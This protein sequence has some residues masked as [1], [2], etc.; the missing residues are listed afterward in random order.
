MRRGEFLLIMAFLTITSSFAK[1]NP[2]LTKGDTPRAPE[3]NARVETQDSGAPSAPE[4]SLPKLIAG[5][6]TLRSAYFNTL[7]IL[8]SSNECSNFFRGSSASVEVFKQ[9]FDKVKKDHVSAPIG[10]QMT[11]MTTNVINTQT[12]NRYRLFEK[13]IINADGPFYRREFSE[14][15]FVS[16]GTF[17]PNTNGARVLMLLHELGHM[18]KG[19]DGEWLL[20]NDGK[21]ESLSQV[22]SQKVEAACGQQIKALGK[23]DRSDAQYSL[24][25]KAAIE[26]TD[27]GKQMSASKR[28]QQQPTST[29]P[30]L[31]EN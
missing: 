14:V 6:K 11:G 3:A 31:K 22:N 29:I 23:E 28:K 25:G 16:I 9:L 13:V 21:D 15:R 4:T 30:M 18:M 12:S 7:R 24:A 27:A 20:P 2:G 5:D 26:E 19:D 10:I 8:S 1:A 17:E